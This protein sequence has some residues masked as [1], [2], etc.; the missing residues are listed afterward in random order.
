MLSAP[1]LLRPLTF[2]ALLGVAPLL[3]AT[4][5]V[6]NAAPPIIDDPDASLAL[7]GTESA[8]GSVLAPGKLVF[9]TAAIDW[10][11]V[12]CRTT[13]PAKTLKVKNVGDKDVPFKISVEGAA[14]DV[15][16][17]TGVA[18]PGS[19]TTFTLTAALAADAPARVALEGALLI[20]SDPG[21][22][23]VRVPLKL[24]PEGA[25]LRV[26]D[27]NVSFGEV[28]VGQLA[29]PV[30]VELENTGFV[31]IEVTLAPPTGDEL[32]LAWTNVPAPIALG[33]TEKKTLSATFAPKSEGKKSADA[34]LTVKGPICGAVPTAIKLSGEGVYKP[35]TVTAGPLLFGAV[36][37]GTTATAKTVSIQNDNAFA[38]TFTAALT[39]A[40][41]SPFTVSPASGSVP[42]GG[43][44]NVTL[45]PKAMTAPRVITANAYGDTL[46]VTTNAPNDTPH[47]VDLQQSARGAIL[48]TTFVAAFG[49][50]TVG[51][52]TNHTLT[53]NNTG[54]A[55]VNVAMATAA[56]FAVSPA[57]PA[58]LTVGA[59]LSANATVSFAPTVTAAQAKNLTFAVAGPLCGSAPATVGLSG[60]GTVPIFSTGGRITTFS[61]T[62]GAGAVPSQTLTLRN[63][64]AALGK[65]LITNIAKTGPFTV[66]PTS[67]AAIDP[68][69]TGSLTITASQ[70]VIGTDRGGQTDPGTITFNTNDPNNPSITV[71][72][73]RAVHGANLDYAVRAGRIL[74]PTSLVDFPGCPLQTPVPSDPFYIRNT[75]DE[76]VLTINT[77]TSGQWT[78]ATSAGLT[79]FGIL[80]GNSMLMTGSYSGPVVASLPAQSVSPA[81]SPSTNV[82]IPLPKLNVTYTLLPLSDTRCIII[83]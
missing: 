78:F 16:P 41:S 8:D 38:V 23:Q 27:E 6:K 63:D 80:A 37:C 26:A 5:C 52:T 50:Q 17:K 83:L 43:S 54:N 10:G 69:G 49:A 32:G 48:G 76:D 65:L 39:K 7:P 35:V 46:T 70:P 9:D 68:G 71:A 67:L 81:S 51:T 45:T 21:V 56:P 12:D 25:M 24:T 3:A 57:S 75:G 29:T 30:T 31:P 22:P 40:A 1:A 47:V 28:K 36:D 74:V 11:F 13:P 58:T 34:A 62:C 42:A 14:F 77:L 73:A 82:C 72:I 79:S 18:L 33:A 4:G 60:S 20:E 66:S 55:S 44:L 64:A 61:A 15:S 2:L 19:E 59:G 53:V